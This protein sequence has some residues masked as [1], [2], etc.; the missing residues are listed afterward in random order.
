MLTK[1]SRARAPIAE[2]RGQAGK[3]VLGVSLG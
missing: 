2:Q 3:G 1:S